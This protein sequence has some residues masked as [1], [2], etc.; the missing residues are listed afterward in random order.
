M[1]LGG[2]TEVRILASKPN[3][4]L[5]LMRERSGR[6][7][8][9]KTGRVT[10]E[11]EC[12]LSREVAL[13]SW[14]RHPG[15]VRYHSHFLHSGY[16]SVMMDYIDG[17]DLSQRIDQARLQNQPFPEPQVSRWL[18]DMASALK[19]LHR[20]LVLHR[21]FTSKNVLLSSRGHIKVGDFGIA[22][23]L[24]GP[25]A[26]ALTVIGTPYYLSPERCQEQPYTFSSDMWSLG[27]VVH[28]LLSLSQ[29]FSGATSFS[30]LL[31]AIMDGPA[32]VPQGYSSELRERAA[33][34]MNQNAASRPTAV[35][36]LH[37]SVEQGELRRRMDEGMEVGR[38][39]LPPLQQ[40][41]GRRHCTSAGVIKRRAFRSSSLSNTELDS[42][43]WNQ[44]RQ[45]CNSIDSRSNTKGQVPSHYLLGDALVS[46]CRVR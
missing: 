29:P 16:I 3:V 41:S 46:P 44:G 19:Y 33:S 38:T 23:M 21:D 25:K 10:D 6:E 4:K 45:S 34:L 15:I 24:D 12:G 39:V 30:E 37:K 14:L 5:R 8:V 18:T 1:D 43:A 36:V 9:V 11:D 35:D 26:H 7:V 42:A 28:E 27:C 2:L 17:G 20:E 40:V 32:P 13:L 31:Q 22:K